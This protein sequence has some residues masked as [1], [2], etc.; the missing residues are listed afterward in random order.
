M[1]T[2][3]EIRPFQRDDFQSTFILKVFSKMSSTLV[4]HLSHQ[5][6]VKGSSL[7]T[8]ADTRELKVFTKMS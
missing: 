4:E 8:T 5:T 2:K 7:A 1:M 3:T 6:K